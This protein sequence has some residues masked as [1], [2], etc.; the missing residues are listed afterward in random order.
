MKNQERLIREPQFPEN[1]VSKKNWGKK[2]PNLIV[3]PIKGINHPTKNATTFNPF[4]SFLFL[5]S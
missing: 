3:N 1:N 4:K 2:P 5:I